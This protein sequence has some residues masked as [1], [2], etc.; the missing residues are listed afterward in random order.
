M[1]EGDIDMVALHDL[2]L[3]RLQ[4]LV[5]TLRKKERSL[6]TAL[7]K[8]ERQTQQRRL[9]VEQFRRE[10]HADEAQRVL[11]STVD[12]ALRDI[13]RIQAEIEGEER[14]RLSP[15]ESTGEPMQT[16]TN[17]SSALAEAN[18]L[19]AQLAQLQH[20]LASQEAARDKL[21]CDLQSR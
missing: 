8:L 13:T 7:Q 21:Q 5:E 14:N 4:E 2:P 12:S 11:V 18:S 3:D 10:R 9:M 16:C 1:T 6:Q 20:S 19:T 15:T 17:H